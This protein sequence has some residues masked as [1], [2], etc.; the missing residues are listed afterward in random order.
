MF[1]QEFKI[2]VL[3]QKIMKISLNSLWLKL[4]LI[5]YLA[6]FGLLFLKSQKEHLYLNFFNVLHPLL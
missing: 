1:D 2:L 5:L 4:Q 6:F 3:I